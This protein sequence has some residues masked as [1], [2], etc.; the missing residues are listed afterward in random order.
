MYIV[1]VQNIPYTECIHLVICIQYTSY[2]KCLHHV[3]CICTEY[4]LHRMYT[5]YSVQCAVCI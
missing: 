3:Y 5:L 4:T 2:K 1:Y